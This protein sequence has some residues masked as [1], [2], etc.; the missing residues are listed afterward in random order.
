[1]EKGGVV[2]LAPDNDLYNQ[3]QW[4]LEQIEHSIQQFKSL[5][6]E[7]VEVAFLNGYCYDFALMYWRVIPNSRIWFAPADVILDGCGHY[8]FEFD[9]HLFD[10]R[11]W[12]GRIECYPDL[13]L[14]PTMEDLAKVHPSLQVVTDT[15]C[16][17][18]S[19][20]GR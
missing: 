7:Q 2:L 12:L 20:L 8:V 13:E 9:G 18:V 11:G 4:T 19:T 6:G 17:V 14:D 10:I 16:V 5:A 15:G 3:H 1:M